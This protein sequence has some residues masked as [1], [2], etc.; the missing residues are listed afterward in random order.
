[1]DENKAMQE[2]IPSQ[3]RNQLNAAQSQPSAAAAES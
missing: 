1:M 3:T 2:K